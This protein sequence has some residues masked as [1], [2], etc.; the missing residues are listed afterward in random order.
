MTQGFGVERAADISETPLRSNDVLLH[1]NR[2]T[3]PPIPQLRDSWMTWGSDANQRQDCLLCV[4]PILRLPK[5]GFRVLFK[6]IFSDLLPSI[7]RQAVQHERARCLRQE[8][9]IDLILLKLRLAQGRL[10]FFS[11]TYPNIR[12]E[13]VRTA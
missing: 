5:D 2:P 1:E 3:H 9:T 13:N 6:D 10:T 8:I 7:R 11:H 4:Q 12:I